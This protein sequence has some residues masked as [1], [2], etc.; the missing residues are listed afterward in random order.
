MLIDELIAALEPPWVAVTDP[1]ERTALEAEL[2]RELSPTHPLY[3]NFAAPMA[4]RLD[5][6]DVAYALA[7]GRVAV[8][9]LTWARAPE[10]PGF[11]GF[12]LFETR[13]AFLA[14]VA[15]DAQEARS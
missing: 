1:I 14:A 7:R 2:A 11:P 4:R 3:Q 5:C 6:D 9:H 15:L 10:M 12:R 13:N 8:V